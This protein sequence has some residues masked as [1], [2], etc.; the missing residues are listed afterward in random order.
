VGRRLE[1]FIAHGAAS[2]LCIDGAFS[3]EH[4]PRMD[5]GLNQKPSEEL[6]AR[7]GTAAPLWYSLFGNYIYLLLIPC[8][9][10]FTIL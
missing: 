10:S 3:E 5:P 9:I 4:I 6:H 7:G 8:M 1:F 2:L